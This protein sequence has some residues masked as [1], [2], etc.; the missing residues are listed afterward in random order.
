MQATTKVNTLYVNIGL[1]F[2]IEMNYADALKFTYV[3]EKELLEY[4]I[5]YFMYLFFILE[6]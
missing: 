1:G 4:Q 6:N 3:K 2:Y 5:L